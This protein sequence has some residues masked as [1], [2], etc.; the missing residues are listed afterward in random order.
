MILTHDSVKRLLKSKEGTELIK[1]VRAEIARLDSIAEIKVN[2]VS[3]KEIAVEVLGRK[4]ASEILV[5][6]LK[7]FVEFSEKPQGDVDKELY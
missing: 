1:G 5:E 6:I 7:P 2:L 4:R 3:E